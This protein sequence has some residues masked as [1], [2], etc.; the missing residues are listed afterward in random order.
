[1]RKE[2]NLILKS[3][4]DNILWLIFRT[5]KNIYTYNSKQGNIHIFIE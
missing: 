5:M 4:N 1:M 3:I 2:Q